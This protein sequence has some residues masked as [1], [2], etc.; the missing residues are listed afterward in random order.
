MKNILDNDPK[1]NTKSIK[2]LQKL[3]DDYYEI[4]KR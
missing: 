4:L 1:I 3:Y 2:E